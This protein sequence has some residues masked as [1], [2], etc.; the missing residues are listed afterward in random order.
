MGSFNC[1][2]AT[3]APAHVHGADPIRC[4]G[5][6]QD[7]WFAAKGAAKALGLR[8]NGKQSLDAITDPAWIVVGKFPTSILQRDGVARVEEKDTTLIN[9]SA[10]FKLAFRSNK[11]EADLSLIG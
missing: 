3:S 2:P 10:V 7:P 1:S 5:T 11:P 4:A 8:W 9:K 6:P